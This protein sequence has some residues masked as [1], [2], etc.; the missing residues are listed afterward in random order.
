MAE[1]Q[2]EAQPMYAEGID[3]LAQLGEETIPDAFQQLTQ[4]R[5][6]I[7]QIVQFCKDSYSA[8]ATGAEGSEEKTAQ[9]FAQTRKYTSDVLLNVTYHVQNI[10]GLLTTY[11]ERQMDEIDKMLVE[12]QVV[13]ERLR[14]HYDRNGS[15]IFRP[16]ESTRTFEKQGK[17]VKLTGLSFE[18]LS[19]VFVFFFIL[20][21][22]ILCLF[23]QATIF[24]NLRVHS[25]SS[26]VV[27]MPSSLLSCEVALCFS[28]FFFHLHNSFFPFLS[29]SSCVFHCR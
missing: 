20:C 16:A 11:V 12:T 18:F 2:E 23:T 3:G 4:T 27:G 25:P 24:P 15:E 28:S 21:F 5:D 26:S 8:S 6:T 17:C 7:E 10:A 29:L 14:S 19:C 9:S 1:G 13:S 22:F